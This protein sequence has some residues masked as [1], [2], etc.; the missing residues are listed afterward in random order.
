MAGCGSNTGSKPTMTADQIFEKKK[1][2][3][4]LRDKMEEQIQKN[5]DYGGCFNITQ[6]FYSPVRNSCLYI[7]QNVWYQD[8]ENCRW[9]LVWWSTEVVIDYLTNE[10][11]LNKKVIWGNQHSETIVG[12]DYAAKS[13]YY[14]AD[15]TNELSKNVEYDHNLTWYDECQLDQYSIRLQELKWE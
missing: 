4:G 14:C 7:M 10:E 11:I 13:N 15:A 2:C 12:G 3:A 9:G 8:N 5:A 6:I 1:E